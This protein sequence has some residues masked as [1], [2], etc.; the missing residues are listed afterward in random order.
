MIRSACLVLILLGTL[1]G[2]AA[3][4]PPSAPAAPDSM[5][6]DWSQMPEYRIVPGDLLVLN[7]GPPPGGVIDVE[8]EMR[9]RPDG[10]ISVFPVGDVIAAGRTPRELEAM[11]VQLLGAE[12]RQPRVTVTVKEVTANLVHVLGRVMKPGPVP[13]TAF[14]TVLQAIAGAGGLQDDAARNSVLVMHRSGAST[15]RVMRVR[16]DRAIRSGGVVDDPPVS[17]FDIVYVPRSSI[18][19]VDVFVR[20]FVGD[21]QPVLS[22]AFVGWELFHLNRVFVVYPFAR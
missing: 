14:M 20:Q 8:R 15:V 21:L 1:A 5:G 13:A 16:L 4:A 10:R 19:N 18:G 11:L 6:I 22:S 9:V 12:L 3:G 7:F 17:R 2:N